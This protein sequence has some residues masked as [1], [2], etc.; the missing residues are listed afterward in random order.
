MLVFKELPLVGL[1]ALAFVVLDAVVRRFFLRQKSFMIGAF[2]AHAK[3]YI[4]H[5]AA[6]L[7]CVLCAAGML[8]FFAFSA[9][10][11][12]LVF[13]GLRM[14]L[15]WMLAAN[16]RGESAHMDTVSAWIGV[17]SVGFGL[18]FVPHCTDVWWP[19]YAATACFL[20]VPYVDAL[21]WRSNFEHRVSTSVVVRG[22]VP[23]YQA[24]GAWLWVLAFNLAPIFGAAYILFAAV[25][26]HVMPA[27]PPWRQLLRSFGF[28]IC[29]LGCAM[30][31]VA[32][33]HLSQ[34]TFF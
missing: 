14:F 2:A 22:V 32:A 1:Y 28:F 10:R 11:V 12:V 18:L 27:A 16:M 4:H 30:M 19:I 7:I 5:V 15:L 34:L 23:V 6:L 26:I 9:G 25:V 33:F 3:D 24:V 17:S 31:A 21:L 29:A 20:L 13:I 8:S